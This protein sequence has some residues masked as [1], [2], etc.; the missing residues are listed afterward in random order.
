MMSMSTKIIDEKKLLIEIKR[1]NS[2]SN[3][4]LFAPNGTGKSHIIAEKYKKDEPKNFVI[5]SF[6]ESISGISTK[7]KK[8]VLYGDQIQKL[9]EE[10]TSKVKELNSNELKKNVRKDIANDEYNIVKQVCKNEVLI[11]SLLDLEVDNP[12]KEFRK[13]NDDNK[14][15]EPKKELKILLDLYSKYLKDNESD[16]CPCCLET[17]IKDDVIEQI[18]ERLITLTDVPKEVIDFYV[19]NDEESRKFISEFDFDDIQKNDIQILKEIKEK[20]EEINALKKEGWEIKDRTD[21]F[22]KY[23]NKFVDVKSDKHNDDT[24]SVISLDS[25]NKLIEIKLA[26]KM[27]EYSTGEHNLILLIL[28][29]M[30]FECSGDDR[31]I[32][33]DI[34]S[35]VDTS[36]MFEMISL[37]SEY[38]NDNEKKFLLLTHNSDVLNLFS[39]NKNI[40]VKLFYLDRLS[41][42]EYCLLEFK[43]IEGNGGVNNLKML[44]DY[45]KEDS[46][47]KENKHVFCLIARDI[48]ETIDMDPNIIK[49]WL[50]FESIDELPERFLNYTQHP[51]NSKQPHELRPHEDILFML[52]NT[53]D[54]FT[55]ESIDKENTANSLI[56]KKFVFLASLRNKLYEKYGEE[57]EDKNSCNIVVSKIDEDP[58]VEPIN[59]E[60]IKRIF[61]LLNSSSHPGNL[62]NFLSF[63]Y[64]IS[65][66]HL[67]EWKEK[68]L[69]IVN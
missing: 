58:L 8:F 42:E 20:K 17:I 36:H 47:C 29:L 15:N 12:I 6:D 24:K 19:K 51:E 49:N 60:L 55:K 32:L 50:G 28:K 3:M 37:I 41:K 56:I 23:L 14:D 63:A 22:E 62:N 38:F 54:D 1:L 11:E 52:E 2:S 16:K 40:K 21:K 26:R 65:I 4:I 64:G 53:F 45:S 68:I 48:C 34:I 61:L 27:T 39:Y 33:D 69:E 9:N 5:S 7:N 30:E 46:F 25:I 13:L 10:I 18:N 57:G 67:L 35:S 44:Y 66:E 59:K 31:L 43:R